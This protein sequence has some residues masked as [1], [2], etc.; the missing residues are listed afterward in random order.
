M[1]EIMIRNSGYD[2]YL[3]THLFFIVATL[4]KEKT[5]KKTHHQHR[6]QSLKA[7]Y[8]PSRKH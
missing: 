1:I 4:S 2:E 7:A 5:L 8:N 6:L 3:N